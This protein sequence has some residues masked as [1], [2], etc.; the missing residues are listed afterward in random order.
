MNNIVKFGALMLALILFIS[1]ITAQD[2]TVNGELLTGGEIQAFIQELVD[3]P[4]S[5]AGETVTVEGVVG[6][7]VNVR[8]FT[9]LEDAALGVD[10]VLVINNSGQP[11]DVNVSADGRFL[12]TGVVH[13]P[14]DDVYGDVSGYDREYY[15]DYTDN[16]IVEDENL[17]LYESAFNDYGGWTIIEVTNPGNLV[18]AVTLQELA[19]GAEPYDDSRVYA[20]EGYV[21]EI[22]NDNLFIIGEGANIANA[23]VLVFATANT[24]SDFNLGVSEFGLD[25][26]TAYDED[27]RVRV[28]GTISPL[29]D[30][31]FND[32]FNDW[33]DFGLDY[34]T[35]YNDDNL[36]GYD[37]DE[38][39]VVFADLIVPVPAE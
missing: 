5:F 35:V 30:E 20:V 2:D 23:R 24:D 9:L 6:Q 17:A 39:E 16:Y 33:N 14:I 32:E 11:Y 13:N 25:Y 31:D 3:D 12:V 19:G 21:N 15:L 38:W 22:I 18:P 7:L 10:G 8:A 37:I 27:Y 29:A 26:N 36:S 34:N 1:P 28:Y 4:A